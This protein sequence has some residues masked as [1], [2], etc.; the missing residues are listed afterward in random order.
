MYQLF[1]FFMITDPKT[2]VRSTRGQVLVVILVAIVEMMLR[3]NEVVYA[4]FYALF[5]VGPVS[6]VVDEWLRTRPFG[7]RVATA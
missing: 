7:T 1:V 2:T 6:L 3:L 5:L 4:P